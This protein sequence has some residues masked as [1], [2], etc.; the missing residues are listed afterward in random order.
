MIAVGPLGNTHPVT[1]KDVTSATPEIQ[2]DN[3][4]PRS[5]HHRLASRDVDA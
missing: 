5:P 2:D 1:W 3:P 4:E